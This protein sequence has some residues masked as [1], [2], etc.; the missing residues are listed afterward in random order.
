[1]TRPILVTGATGRQGGAVA[2]HLLRLGTPVRALTRRADSE[3]AQDLARLGATLVQ[4][5]LDRP[6]T[7]PQALHGVRA[8]FSVQD[9][10]QAGGEG[11]VR[12]AH[13]LLDAA[14]RDGAPFVLQSTMAT[15]NPEAPG[16]PRV[17]HFE[18]KPEI[19]RLVRQSGLPHAFLGTV[20]FMDN[21]RDPDMGGRMTFPTLAGTL[22]PDT[23]LD[24]VAVEDLGTVAAHILRQPDAFDGQRVDVVGDRLTVREMRDAYRRATGRRAKRWSLPRWALRRL[25]GEFA[26]QLAWHNAVNFAPDTNTARRLHPRIQSFETYLRETVHERGPLRL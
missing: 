1:M 9:Y 14:S 17:E 4:A 22:A 20:F 8:V 23:P 16:A 26:D 25:A 2:R 11:E 7:L 21:V 15:A 10:W 13:H 12:Q 19:E 3:N 24:L 18:S 6:G 5:D